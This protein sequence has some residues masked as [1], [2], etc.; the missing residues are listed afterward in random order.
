MC[1]CM[2]DARVGTSPASSMPAEN[3]KRRRIDALAQPHLPQQ[4]RLRGRGGSVVP[5]LRA[6]RRRHRRRRSHATDFP[7]P[8]TA[9]LHPAPCPAEGPATKRVSGARHRLAPFRLRSIPL[10]CLHRWYRRSF[11]FK[12]TAFPFSWWPS[13]HAHRS[14]RLR[15]VERGETLLC[16]RTLCCVVIRVI[17]VISVG[18]IGY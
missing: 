5:G 14:R 7:M 11:G 15:E 9:N 16:N 13:G 6:Y 17:R 10:P 4:P 12:N 18:E 3:K 8:A 2:H 1:V